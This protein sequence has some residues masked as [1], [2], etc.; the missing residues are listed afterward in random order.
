MLNALAPDFGNFT[1]NVGVAAK[2]AVSSEV[3]NLGLAKLWI[4]ALSGV[5]ATVLTALALWLWGSYITGYDKLVLQPDLAT[6]RSDLSALKLE[7]E[8]L[9]AA[10]DALQLDERLDAFQAKLNDLTMPPSPLPEKNPQ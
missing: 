8:K 4:P 9:K 10:G 1:E 3:H 7:M 5:L 2:K 6:V